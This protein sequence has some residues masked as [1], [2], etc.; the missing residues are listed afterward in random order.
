MPKFEAVNSAEDMPMKGTMEML[1]V[2]PEGMEN[3]GESPESY[4]DIGEQRLVAAAE[5]VR[6]LGS[7][8]GGFMGRAWGKIKS[9]GSKTKE[10]GK[11]A[12]LYTLAAPEMIHDAGIAAKEKVIEG[13][14][15]VGDKMEEG[16]EYVGDKGRAAYEGA[17]DIGATA[18][19]MAFEGAVTAYD[20]TAEGVVYVSEKAKAGY[21]GA[22]NFGKEKYAG[23]QRRAEDARGIF[24]AAVNEA[25]RRRE[26]R[27]A[28]EQGNRE[29]EDALRVLRLAQDRVQMFESRLGSGSSERAA[30]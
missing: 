11:T 2:K 3:K 13:A 5:R 8:A 28:R 15:Y 21:E 29:Y 10:A 7:K 30:A 14:T 16:V 24:Q 20:K 9:F 12:L 23:L 18:A 4:R 17:K 1:G 19:S 27:L 25:R 22:V 6:G 26:E